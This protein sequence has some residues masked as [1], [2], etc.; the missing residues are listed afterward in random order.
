V[1]VASALLVGPDGDMDIGER[2][3]P[4]PAADEALV[5]VEWAG[6][7]GSDLHV[8]RTGAWVERWPATLG[9]EIY[10]RVQEAGPATGLTHGQAVVADSRIPCGDCEA[11]ATDPDRCLHLRFVGEA[12]PGGFASHCV[13]PGRALH[14]VPDGLDGA[15]AVLAEPLAVVLHGLSRLGPA[16]ERARAVA[17]LGHGPIGALAH[18]EV[19][20]RRPDVP[21]AVAEPAPL[22]RRLAIALGATDAADAADLPGPGGYDVVIDAAGHAGALRDAVALAA[23]GAAVLLVAIGHS[24]AK[25]DAGALAE[26]RLLLIGVNAFVDE[27]P[28]AIAR[29]AAEGWRYRP[30]VTHAVSLA[31]LP[32]MARRQLAEPD[33][34]KVLVRP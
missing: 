33:A 1:T 11:C 4:A 34:V 16:L 7:C 6:L 32:V 30:V 13:L 24:D 14:P 27:L 26:R 3:L 15:L 20:R 19:R 28:A 5:R 9:H 10:G 8:L 29:L 21:I 25:V 23:P 12:R 17:V 31:E 22:R 18:V 2:T